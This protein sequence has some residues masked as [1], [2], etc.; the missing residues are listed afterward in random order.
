VKPSSCGLVSDV[1]E[2]LAPLPPANTANLI[3][4]ILEAVGKS[5]K[6]GNGNFA[7]CPRSGGTTASK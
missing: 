7:I 4:I 3:G 1:L 5:G 2:Q 6:A